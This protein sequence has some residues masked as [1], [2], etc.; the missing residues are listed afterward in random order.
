VR[1]EASS[2][3]VRCPSLRGTLGGSGDAKYQRGTVHSLIAILITLA[4]LFTLGI[5][6]LLMVHRW[7]QPE[8]PDHDTSRDE[9][10]GDLS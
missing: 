10:M 1:S 6:A 3:R 5:G 2:A 7:R 9:E 8:P 4:F